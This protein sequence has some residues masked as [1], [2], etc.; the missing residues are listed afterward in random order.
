MQRNLDRRV[1]DTFPILDK[2]IKN[3]IINNILK[4][5]LK[6]NCKAR[7]LESNGDYKRVKP[8]KGEPATCV[9]EY[10]MENSTVKF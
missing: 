9:Q 2:D 8:L 1:E 10:L 6:D 4:V 3:S 5:Y 7:K